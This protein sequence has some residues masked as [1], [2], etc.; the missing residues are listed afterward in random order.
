MASAIPE[1]AGLARGT[2]LQPVAVAPKDW[3]NYRSIA[4]DDILDDAAD[5]AR[6]LR[7]AR[8]LH[9]NATAYGGGV[10]ELLTS[11]IALLR[12]LGIDAEWRVICPDAAFFEV[13]K[14][15][16]NAMQGK[17]AGLSESDRAVYVERNEHCAA[18]L[19]DEWDVV[20][21]HDPQPA[22]LRAYDPVPGARWIW[23]CHIDTSTPDPDAWAFLGS[24]VSAYDAYVFTLAAFAPA[25]FERDRLAV[26]APAIDPLSTKNC[27]LPH[28]LARSTVAATGIDLARPLVVQVSRFD[29]WKDPLGVVEAWR[30]ARERV[31]GLQ[32]ALVGSMAD[33]DPE[34][35]G[36]YE[37]ARKATASE[38]D[39]HLL[40]NQTG[41]G[42]LEVNAFQREADVVVQK[43]LREGFGL[44]VAE[45][46]WK[47]TPVV[48]GDAGGIPLQIGDD[49]AGVLVDNVE[50]CAAAV[51]ALLEDAELAERKGRIGRDRVRRDFLIPRLARDDLALYA[52]V[53]SSAAQG[54]SAPSDHH[55]SPEVRQ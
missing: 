24:Y 18:M 20:V 22:A 37:L 35:W 38:P 4:P 43:S 45:A 28:F 54:A 19:A 53:L 41:I 52:K 11:E 32:L 31:P 50:D 49:E 21:I 1:E 5:S 42:A 25:E 40:T 55:G 48:G 36:I 33:D 9:V 3:E 10:A 16:H 12:D 30:I 2:T 26:I 39:C 8:I 47:E 51:V 13:T 6:A 44:T 15:I 7:G 29:P 23:R 34:G 46:L 17:A 27:S 14:Q